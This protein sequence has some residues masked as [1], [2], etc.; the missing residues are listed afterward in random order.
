MHYIDNKKEG[1]YTKYHLLQHPSFD[2]PIYK[3]HRK[4]F[5]P[6]SQLPQLQENSHLLQHPSFDLPIYKLH[7]KDFFPLSQLPQ[8]QENSPLPVF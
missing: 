8:L 4:D 2:L 3:L 6:L 5:F 1:Y 7:R